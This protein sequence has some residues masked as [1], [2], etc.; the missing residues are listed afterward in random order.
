MTTSTF[1]ERLRQQFRHVRQGFVRQCQQIYQYVPPRFAALH[2]FVMEEYRAIGRA[3]RPLR[4]KWFDPLWANLQPVLGPLYRAIM[5]RL[6]IWVFRPLTTLLNR[7]FPNGMRRWQSLPETTR[8]RVRLWAPILLVLLVLAVPHRGP[9]GVNDAQIQDPDIIDITPDSMELDNPI[10]VLNVQPVEV[11]PFSETLRVT[12]KVA[13]DEQRV[14]RIG[15]SVTGRVID[16]I[17]IPGQEV[18]PGDVLARINSTELGQ[19]QL[20][21]LKARAADE[22]AQRAAE[23]A[24]ILYK[25]D[26]IAKAD[27]QRRESEASTAA[28][29]RRAMADQLRVLGMPQKQIDTLGQTGNVNSI[30]A[31]TASIPGTVVER[32]IAQGQVVQPADALFTV[33]DLSVVWVTAQVPEQEAYLLA[34]G[35]PMRIEVP[36]LKNRVY[37]GQLVHVSELVSNDS[38]TV[39]AR[40]AIDNPDRQLKPGMLATMLISGTA[41]DRPVVPASAVIREDGYDHVFVA[42]PNN[43]FKL[44][45][46]R[47]GAESNGLRP[48]ISG[49]E[50]GTLIVTAQAYHLNNERKKRLSGG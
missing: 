18:E 43:Q 7:L 44:V 2:R 46:V 23:R 35:Q 48:V 25:E 50:P 19:A 10:W 24:R 39:D 22:L 42:L 5:L 47:L 3:L 38:R 41:V 9:R 14:A 37:E 6:D 26:V 15:A 8:H 12:G 4:Q 16:V 32:R 40:T 13:F 45:I 30:S 1:S 17:A 36:A 49:L 21:F 34:P 28:A 29:E 31:V 20:A 33:S 11:R 27:L